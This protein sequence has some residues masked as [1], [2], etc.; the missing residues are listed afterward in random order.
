MCAMFF[1]PHSH[2]GQNTPT[3]SDFIV[4]GGT[5]ISSRLYAEP[6]SSSMPSVIASR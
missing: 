3:S 2:A 6:S 1:G 4:P 5:L